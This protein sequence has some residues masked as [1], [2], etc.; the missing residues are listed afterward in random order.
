ML[1]NTTITSRLP[2]QER[3]LIGGEW[4][5]AKDGLT[6]EIDNPATGELI[7]RVPLMGADE[8]R[9]AIN[10]AHAAF[11]AW[12]RTT[13]QQR[14]DTLLRWQTLVLDNAEALA[15]LLTLEQGKPLEEA[16]GEI[17]YAASF[18]RFYAEEARRTYGETIPS[19]RADGRI[20]V[21]KQPL[22]VV[23]CIIPWNFPAAMVTRKVAPA[24]AAGCTVVMKPAE[25]T[26]LSAI[27]LAKLAVDAG[28][29]AGV[30]NIVTGEPQ[31]IGAELCI[32]PLVRK[33]SFTGS[34]DVGRLLAAQSAGS[35]KKLAL[36]LGG[37]APFIVFDDADLDAAVEG[38]VLS[39]FRHSGQT[40][41]C[42]NRFLIQSNVY[43]AFAERLVSRVRALK[44]GNGLD[45]GVDVG[46]LINE[47]AVAKI[48]RLVSEAVH[49]G[50]SLLAG[51]TRYTPNNRFF[52]PTVLADVSPRMSVAIEEV[53]GPVASLMRFDD[54]AE[55]VALA[56][57]TEYGL[58][59]YFYTRDLARAWRV[60]ER[61]ECGM[62]GI[63]SGFLSMEVAPFGGIKQSGIGREG[64][65]HGLTEFLEL[66][67]LHIGGIA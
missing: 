14:A 23:G 49:N 65:H 33:I 41:V 63:N 10:A 47:R 24:I 13:A 3:A 58:A 55:A 5:D 36:E 43:D 59:G 8:T 1:D 35:V 34:T 37:N 53:F 11:G 9:R 7:A 61:I 67:Y 60:A 51:G 40:C 20:M 54:E 22:G 52:A 32:N 27:A 44:V 45:A 29:P 18:L 64:S 50:A 25:A 15:R 46:P 31:S 2:L 21:L 48:E 56:N 17:A 12:S 30:L 38:A 39:K 66:K 42:T 28:L 16:R 6:F 62:V 4:L 57:D 26:P 19:P